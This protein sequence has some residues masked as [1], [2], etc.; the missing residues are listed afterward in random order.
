MQ[1]G[2]VVLGILHKFLS[3]LGVTTFIHV[4]VYT[5]SIVVIAEYSLYNPR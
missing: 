2:I 5:N 3:L 4:T 1:L